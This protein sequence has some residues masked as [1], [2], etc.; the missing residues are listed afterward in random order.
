V[1][2]S[3]IVGRRLSLLTDAITY[4]A[5]HSKTAYVSVANSEPGVG[6]DQRDESALSN[7]QDER[8]SA[9]VSD[10]AKGYFSRQL[11]AFV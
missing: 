3:K 8:Y 5:R 10:A 11:G 6:V 2:I 9:F 1:S 4:T 7:A